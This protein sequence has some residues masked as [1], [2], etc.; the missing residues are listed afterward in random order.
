MSTYLLYLGVGEFEFLETKLRNIKIRV[1]TTRGKKSKAKL[2]LELTKKFLAE[3]EKY[4]GIKYPLPKLDML[5]IPD[6]AAGAMEN[7]GAITFRETILLYDPKTSSTKTKQYIAEV[8]SHEIAHQWFGNLVT[9]KWWNDLWVNEGFANY[10]EMYGTN[11]VNPQFR[12]LDMQIPTGWQAAI[13]SDALKNTHPVNQ[14]VSASSEIG[15]MFDTISYNKGASL[16][17]MVNGFMGDSFI[18]GVKSYVKSYTFGNAETDDLWA[19]LTEASKLQSEKNPKLQALDIKMIMDTWTNQPGFPVVTIN[20]ISDTKL[21]VSQ[22]SII[23]LKQKVNAK[24]PLNATDDEAPKTEETEHSWHVPFTYILDSDVHQPQEVWL[25]NV[26]ETEVTVPEGMRWLKAN[27]DSFGFYIVNYDNQ[28]WSNLITALK[29]NH[30]IFNDVDRAN[31]IHDAFKLSCEGIIDPV[32][33]LNLS[34]YLSKEED[35]LPWAM[36]RSK[37]ECMTNLMT[38]KSRKARY[39]KYFWNQ[40]SH[41]VDESMLET[42]GFKDLTVFEK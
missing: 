29:T 5:A 15:E 12:S 39:K 9:M 27:L 21:S 37:L 38:N 28:T 32:I 4:F 31:L 26:K 25:Q 18:E 6:F 34:Q 8:I 36:A 33:A 13:A 10:V 22:E 20:R 19:H 30:T 41:L 7:W 35:Y 3:Y 23:S 1:V 14:K 42:S 24:V 2:S 40:Q 17:R 11:E 16:L